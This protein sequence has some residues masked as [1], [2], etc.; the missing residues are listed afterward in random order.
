LSCSLRRSHSST[1]TNSIHPG[2]PLQQRKYLILLSRKSSRSG[3]SLPLRAFSDPRAMPNWLPGYRHRTP[4]KPRSTRS[5]SLPPET[6]TSDSPFIVRPPPLQITANMSLHHRFVSM[7][8]RKGGSPC[9]STVLPTGFVA[10]SELLYGLRFGQTKSPGSHR[11]KRSRQKR[12]KGSR[13]SSPATTFTPIR[14]FLRKS[15]AYLSPRAHRDH[16]TSAHGQPANLRRLASRN[17][18]ELS[19][20]ASS[21]AKSSYG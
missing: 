17:S 11:R 4:S 13:T 15:P 21:P 18:G 5:R 20:V 3:P 12:T 10:G 2:T 6:S 8:F 1:N 7:G 19:P 16:W 14:K 9:A